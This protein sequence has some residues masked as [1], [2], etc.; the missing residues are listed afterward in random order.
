MKLVPEKIG[1][2]ERRT[3]AVVAFGALVAAAT[4]TV[5][6]GE[7]PEKPV[8][9]VSADCATHK[10]GVCDDYKVVFR[11]CPDDEH[12]AGADN[13]HQSSSQV[14]ED[15]D[16]DK[17]EQEYHQKELPDTF[18]AGNIIDLGERGYDLIEKQR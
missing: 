1:G 8:Q 14:P 16:C 7:Q 4:L 13:L 3:V 18:E 5:R 10:L 2:F 11:Q 6:G 17:W 9:V 12:P 15:N